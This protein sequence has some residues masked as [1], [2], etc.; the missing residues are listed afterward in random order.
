VEILKASHS[1]TLDLLNKR[2]LK[3]QFPDLDKE[4]ISYKDLKLRRHR[5]AQNQ[6]EEGM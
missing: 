1:K 4:I 6:I 3:G 5:G 2:E